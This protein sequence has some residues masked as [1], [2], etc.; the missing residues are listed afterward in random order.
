MCGYERPRDFL[1]DVIEAGQGGDTTPQLRFLAAAGIFLQI[2]QKSSILSQPVRHAAASFH[3]R[4][5][6]CSRRPN[7]RQLLCASQV[8]AESSDSDGDV[9][10]S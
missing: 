1:L 7:S 10:V 2:L 9:L 8:N 6:E 4:S 3:P 5:I